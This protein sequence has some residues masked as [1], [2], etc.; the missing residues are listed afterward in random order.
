MNGHM[1]DE[2]K[3]YCYL[4]VIIS[5]NGS[6]STAV[7]SLY[8]KGRG[9]YFSL[10]STVARLFIKA[11]CLDKL[12]N[13]LI[14]PILTYGCQV[15]FPTMSIAKNLVCNFR[16]DGMLNLSSIAKMPLEQV[17]LRHLKFL[18]GINR[19]SS[20]CAAWGETGSRPLLM[21]CLKLSIK[22]LNRAM[23]LPASSLVKAALTE[24]IQLNL[25]WYD[26]MKSILECFG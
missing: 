19:R 11:K 15:W 10:R 25:T 24:Q 9:G 7:N 1:I 14:E 5:S 20:N 18:L 13:T 21:N 2:V 16:H 6:F 23:S 22:F 17:H 3:S 4:G 8:R 12:F 26:N